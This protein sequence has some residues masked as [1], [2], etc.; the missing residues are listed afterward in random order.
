VNL[1]QQI[2]ELPTLSDMAIK[3]LHENTY[4]P[5]A[6]KAGHRDALQTAADM[7]SPPLPKRLQDVVCS[8]CSRSDA[9]APVA[10][11]SHSRS[12]ICCDCID[13]AHDRLQEQRGVRAG[14]TEYDSWM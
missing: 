10:V 13:K 14:S 1:H 11:V 7:V 8:F 5:L 3:Y 4:G 12:T 2:L 9:E 6:Y